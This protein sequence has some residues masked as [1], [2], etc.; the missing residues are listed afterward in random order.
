MIDWLTSEILSNFISLVFAVF[1]M[2]IGQYLYDRF[3]KKK[4]K[5]V[6][7]MGEWVEEGEQLVWDEI[8]GKYVRKKDK[9]DLV[10][11]SVREEYVERG[12]ELVWDEILDEY[13]PKNEKK[14][15][16]WDDVRNEYVERG[17]EMVWDDVLGKYVPKNEKKRWVWD[18]N[19]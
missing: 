15:W 8:L 17:R 10:W 18:L 12:K 14:D 1:G 3:I 5:E 2:I 19:R 11:D 16:V 13:V 7:E 4:K 6:M 9:K